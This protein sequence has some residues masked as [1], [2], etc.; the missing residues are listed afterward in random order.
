LRYL[1]LIVALI[2]V[3]LGAYAQSQEDE[4]KGFIVNLIEEN[5]SGASRSVNIVGFAGAL[6]SEATIEALTVADAEGVWLTLEDVT[7]IWSRSALLRGAIDIDEISATRIIV[8]RAPVSE[9]TGPSPEAQPFS[10]P[11]LPVS[12]SLEQLEIAEIQLGES[13][14]GEPISISLSGNAQLNGGEGSANVVAERLGDKS[15]IFEIDGS[16]V[17]ETKVLGMLLNLEEGADGIAAR[18]LDL[19]DRPAIGLQID[20]TAPIDNY[21]AT[22]A[23]ATDGQ[24]RLTGSFGLASDETEQLIRLDVGGDVRP[25]FD[26]AYRDFFGSDARLFA[27]GRQTSDGRI[28]VSALDLTS[29]RLN[30]K[31]ALLIGAQGWPQLIDLTGGIT[32][33]G[34]PV[35][36]PISGDLT[37]VGGMRLDIAYDNNQSDD[38]R[39]DISIDDFERPGLSIDTLSLQGGGILRDGEGDQ[40]GLVTAGLEYGAK[41]LQ[42]DDAGAAQALGDEIGG[43]FTAR[44]VEGESTQISS[45]TLSGAGIEAAAQATIQGPGNGL[46]TD[47]TATFDVDGL[48]RFASLIGQDLGGGAAL[49]LLA[50]ITPLDGLFD[51][52]L[53][54]TTDDLRVGVEQVDAVLVGQGRLLAAAVRD[55]DGTRL[56][57]LNIETDAALIT[58]NADLTSDGSDATFTARLND[59]DLVAPGLNGPAA[60]QG[61]ILQGPNDSIDWCSQFHRWWGATQ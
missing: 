13:F 4:D 37:Y 27:E 58:A 7:L 55:V 5:L 46:R 35:L 11:E 49:N 53:N 59:L 44:R 60:A 30:L 50:S 48:E 45:F 14:L 31:G 28:D 36:L 3:P 51:I 20:G 10:L 32:A 18:I 61:T 26:P 39:A 9:D 25:L 34:E 33:D 2:C 12:I 8:A 38:W 57:Q 22:I 42:L 19:P 24:D 1:F 56:E 41:G 16:Y 21:E 29:E 6:S 17:N 54:G 40:T 47:L 52:T 23:I 43:V 15:G